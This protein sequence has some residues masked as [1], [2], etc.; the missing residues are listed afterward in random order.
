MNEMFTIRLCVEAKKSRWETSCQQLWTQHWL[1]SKWW[2]GRGVCELT[3]GRH[4]GCSQL[5][6]KLKNSTQSLPGQHSELL[7]T[8]GLAVAQS[9]PAP[10][11]PPQRTTVD[12]L[13][14]WCTLNL[15]GKRNISKKLRMRFCIIQRIQKPKINVRVH[16]RHSINVETHP[17]EKGLSKGTP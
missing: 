3:L 10:L 17:L 1:H 12:W 14:T 7:V 16:C 6:E 4:A 15:E 5:S 9:V 8:C 11:S 13:F 2:P